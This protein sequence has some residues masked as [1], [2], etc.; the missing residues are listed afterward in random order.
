MKIKR[1]IMAIFCMIF[2][3]VPV[4]AGCGDHED[5]NEIKEDVKVENKED[6][7][8]KEE[9]KEDII[10]LFTNDIHC[11]GE[12][13]IGYSGLS[14]YK[15]ECLTKTPYVSLVDCGDAIKGDMFG[16]VREEEYIIRFLN[17]I[18]NEVGYDLA[19]FG[20]HEFDYGTDCVKEMVEESSASYVSCNIEYQGDGESFANEIKPYE[21]KE[22][23]DKKVGFVGVMTPR[24][25]NKNREQFFME[26]GKIVYDFYG[27]GDGQELYECVQRNVDE[28][29]E[30][31]ADYIVL[32]SHLGDTE[33][34]SPY[35]SV[36]LI[37]HTTGIDV[38]LDAHSHSTIE[39]QIEQNKENKEVLLTS[40][41][42]EFSHIGQLVISPDG[43][44]QTSLIS[45]YKE[46][47][48]EID[49]LIEE[50]KYC[51]ES[52][53]EKLDSMIQNVK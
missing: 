14:A 16:L 25:M 30:Q 20:N 44:M 29:K 7:E 17:I 38:V 45:D 13:N 34:K 15:K 51:Y 21:I 52:D 26:N 35:T 3:I 49:Q 10:I 28:C 36:E 24:V 4:F 33:D 8:V 2:L 37:Q 1:K 23:G 11:S 18:M 22:Y 43:E 5:N 32:L 27:D 39:Q 48:Q 46:R 53:R 41:G 9:P 47:D 19:V 12:N 42:S 40:A 31:G 50:L 6:I